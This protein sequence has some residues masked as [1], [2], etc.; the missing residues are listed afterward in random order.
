MGGQ[1]FHHEVVTHLTIILIARRGVKAEWL[2]GSTNKSAGRM[3][4][5]PDIR[6]PLGI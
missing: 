5:V 4:S 1:C 3:G 6:Y 2:L